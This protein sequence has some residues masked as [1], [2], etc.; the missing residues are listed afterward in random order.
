VRAVNALAAAQA[1]GSFDALRRSLYEHQP[2]E[3]TGG[4]TTQTLLEL[5]RDVG[6]TSSSYV[7]A[8]R[9]L[10]YEAWVREVDDQSSKD[11]NVQTPELRIGGRVLDQQDLFDEA[12][13]RQA[14]GI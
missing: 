2:K 8:V 3:R 13:F 7:D 4:Y 5:G 9:D 14:L 10:Q 12:R 1:A 11:G 6:L